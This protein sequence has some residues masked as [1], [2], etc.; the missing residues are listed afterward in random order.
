MHRTGRVDGGGVSVDVQ[1]RK[2]R[3]PLELLIRKEETALLEQALMQ[4]DPKV[5]AIVILRDAESLS[6]AELAQFL[7][8]G[9]G[10]VKS[11]VHR[12]RMRLKKVMTMLRPDLFAK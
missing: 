10:T 2:Q 9:L 3:T 12:A 11:R 1:D 8:C 5:R 6:Y 4:L 7:G